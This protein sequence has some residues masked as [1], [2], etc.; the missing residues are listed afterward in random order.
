MEIE[1]LIEE[2]KTTDDA[3]R[4]NELALGLADMGYDEVVPVLIDLIKKLKYT[5]SYATLIYALGNLNC[6][7]E[8]CD[9]LDII[10]HGNWEASNNMLLLF[11]KKYPQMDNEHKELCQRI[12]ADEEDRAKDTL[13][14]IEDVNDTLFCV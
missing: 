9:I 3:N 2:L 8:I 1:A 7:N 12:F 11:K 4:R 5:D 10:F 6:A 14:M 13:D